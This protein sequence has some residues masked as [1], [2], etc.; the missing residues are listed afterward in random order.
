MKTCAVTCTGGRPELFALCRRWVEHQTVRPDHWIVVTDNGESVDVPSWAS[1]ASVSPLFGD[2]RTP[3]HKPNHALHQALKLVPSGHAAIVFE[4]DDYYFPNHVASCVQK[5][6]EGHGVTYCNHVIE[7][8]LPAGIWR[9]HD[10]PGA[11]EGRVG[12]HPMDVRLYAERLLNRPLWSGLTD[13]RYPILTTVGIKGAG[14][15]LPGRR[16]ATP[17]HGYN[18]DRSNWQHDNDFSKF[19]S[20]IGPDAESYIRLLRK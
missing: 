20:L 19:R 7:F 9:R 11:S 17:L 18:A 3:D 4:D 12:I 8:N 10:K 15:G 13:G 16:G 6:E 14:F 5:L 2:P 1:F